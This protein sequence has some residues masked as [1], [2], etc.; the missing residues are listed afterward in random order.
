MHLTSCFLLLALWRPRTLAS[1]TMNTTRFNLQQ[2]LGSQRDVLKGDNTVILGA[3]VVGLATAYQLAL[4]HQEAAS[5]TSRPPGKI[6]V[7]ERAA[8]IS[9]AASGQATGGLGDFG[10]ASGVT[11]LG[12]LS[13]RLI[14]EVALANGMEE[15]GFTESTIYRIIPDNFTDTPKPP[16]TWGPGPPVEQPV[17]A[18][19]DWIKPR[20]HWSVQRMAGTPHASHLYVYLSI[21]MT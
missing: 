10:F 3:G 20:S 8:H 12:A 19:P 11:D 2:P 9:P 7:I 4:A 16:D 17:S 14:Q 21:S 15:F 1:S 13:Y 6:I 5:A 18:L